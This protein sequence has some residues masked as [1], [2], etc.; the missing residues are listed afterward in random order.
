MP[1]NKI[2]AVETSCDDT[3]VAILDSNGLV[4]GMIS[5]SQD[6]F[7]EPF[8][9]IVPEI[10][11]RA[12]SEKLLPLIEKLLI[13]TDLSWEDISALAVTSRPG[14]VGSLLV[15]LVTVKTLALSLNKPF[16]GV[17]HLEGHI[18]AP[19]VF[20]N[21][22]DKNPF[23]EEFLS[24]VVSGGHTQ[25][26]HV[27]GIGKYKVL[28][29][30][31]D[32]A[33]GEAFDKFAKIIGLGYPGGLV[34]DQKAK[35]GDVKKYSFPRPMLKV[36]NFDFSFSGLKTAAMNT[37]SGLSWEQIKQNTPDLCASYQEAIVDVLVTKLKAASDSMPYLPVTITGGVSANSRLR[38]QVT[39]WS[40]MAKVKCYFPKLQFCT[41]N[42]AMIGFAGLLRMSR[43]EHSEQ[44]LGPSPRSLDRDFI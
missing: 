8:G 3:S 39:N 32:D 5:A 41:D 20:D 9:G 37:V 42:A 14:L 35:V 44:S 10:A 15:G 29:H 43:G 40:N 27:Q 22:K 2:L 38:D 23:I 24:L 21:E 25:L 1:L 33:A 12:H 17:N 11:G 28:G 36:D 13:S 34:I 18:W 19:F 6:G 26:I 7:H 30:S 31:I 16:I 4:L